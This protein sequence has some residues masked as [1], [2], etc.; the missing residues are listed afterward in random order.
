MYG[1]LP[2]YADA[3]A[4]LFALIRDADV[5]FPALDSLPGLQGRDAAAHAEAAAVEALLAGLLR[6]QPTERL[7]LDA[8]LVREHAFCS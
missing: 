4:Q 1:S 3:P 7:S 2:F 8:V 5:P 6:K